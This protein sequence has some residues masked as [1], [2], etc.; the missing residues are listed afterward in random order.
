MMGDKIK[1]YGG[2]DVIE[3]YYKEKIKKKKTIPKEAFYD[4]FLK[5]GDLI[6]ISK[7]YEEK[8]KAKKY[9]ISPY[10]LLKDVNY[11]EVFGINI[12]IKRKKE[13]Y[14]NN[15]SFENFTIGDIVL[16]TS[17]G[18]HIQGAIRHAAIFDSRRYHGSVDDE[19]LL[20]AE[21]NKGVIYESIRF[22]HE[23]FGE[24]WG[25]YVPNTTLQQRIA[26]VDELAKHIGERY[27]WSAHKNNSKVWYCSL[28]P[29]RGYYKIMGIDIDYND[30]YW[31]LPIDI[32]MSEYTEVFEYSRG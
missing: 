19:C 11:E 24:A 9:K 15:L 3:F 22:Y 4:R 18:F 32:F 6:M 31:V 21:P 25:L 30:G 7:P 13:S 27:Y 10:E 2:I 12:P 17:L 1:K 5:I 20:T 8:L 23:N 16:A 26:V 14:H 28:V 29:W